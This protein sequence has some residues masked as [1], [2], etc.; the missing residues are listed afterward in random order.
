ML[1]SLA[2]ACSLAGGLPAQDSG[3]DASARAVEEP[4]VPLSAA[5]RRIVIALRATRDK[6]PPPTETLSKAV[7]AAAG[8]SQQRL[9]AILETRIVPA[10]DGS[11]PQHLS[12]VQEELVLAGVKSL[13]RGAVMPT[14]EQHLAASNA[15]ATRAGAIA[16]LG[17]FGGPADLQK[18][19][20]LAPSPEDKKICDE[21]IAVALTHAVAA[22]LQRDARAFDELPRAT[23]WQSTEVVA[24]VVA[25]IGEARNPRGL[26][27]LSELLGSRPEVAAEV[28]AQ[29]QL[30]GPSFVREVDIECGTRALMFASD[31]HSSLARAAI[32]AVGMLEDERA[33]S[34]LI[35]LLAD[36]DEGLRSD[37]L[38]SL[39]RITGNKLPPLIVE[40]T[41]W[42]AEEDAWYSKEL[43]RVVGRLHDKDRGRAAAAIKT[44]MAHRLYRHELA[45]ALGDLVTGVDNETSILAS[46]ALG[47]LE[48]PVAIPWL[49]SASG[50]D[51][52]NVAAASR[53]ALARI[54]ARYPRTQPARE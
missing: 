8:E 27:F 15:V 13:G 19:V 17:L 31:P 12:A 23:Q 35:V 32:L 1:A 14:V 16:V 47:Q 48:S 2:I 38:W 41:R 33:V 3:P 6:P 21:R 11:R 26:A 50:Y 4:V 22:V 40:W 42:Y 43:P 25:G 54:T 24:A 29:I 49:T 45:A 34:T 37:V 5:E 53:D 18:L 52:R 20:A 46:Q 39:H 51:D 44:C 36:D 28:V 30:V 10:I 7:I 9:L